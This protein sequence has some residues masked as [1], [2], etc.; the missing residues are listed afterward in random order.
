MAH[1]DEEQLQRL[2]HREL[3]ARA[4]SAAREHVA[5]CVECRRRLSEAEQEEAEVHGLLHAVDVPPPRIRAEAVALRAELDTVAART[6]GSAWLR[7]AAGVLL[8]VGIAGAAYAVPGSPVRGWVHAVV[9]QLGGPRQRPA[10]APAPG[11]AVGAGISVLPEEKLSI[12]FKLAQGDGQVFVSLTD[13]PE[14]RVHAP[15]GAATFT[16]GSGRLLIDVRD[17]SAAF[18]VQIPRSAPW[19]EIRVGGDRVFLKEASG[20]TT[21]GSTG[22]VGGYL[23]RLTPSEP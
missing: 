1:L 8:A 9:E 7:R 14:V 16:S 23:L 18:E 19:V 2:L 20:V 12:L 10:P 4:E 15:T 21:R 6:R 13:G 3:P 17:P 22:A 5:G 11:I